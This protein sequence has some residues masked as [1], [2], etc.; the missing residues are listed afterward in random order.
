MTG[1]FVPQCFNASIILPEYAPTYVRR[2][3][4]NTDESDTPPKDIL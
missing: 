4:F 1:L 2:W 3:P